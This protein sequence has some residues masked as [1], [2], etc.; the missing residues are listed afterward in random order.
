M[1]KK[2]RPLGQITSDLEPLLEEMLTGH[3]LQWYEVLN[4]I[5]GYLMAHYPNNQEKYIDDSNPIFYYGPNR[6]LK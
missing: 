4:I 2:L 3:D 6:D 5:H 1:S